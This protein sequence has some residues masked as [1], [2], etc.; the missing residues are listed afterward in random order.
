MGR[1]R[2]KHVTIYT[3]FRSGVRKIGWCLNSRVRFWYPD[4]IDNHPIL[5]SRRLTKKGVTARDEASQ[6]AVTPQDLGAARA[7]VCVPVVFSEG[8]VGVLCED[9]LYPGFVCI[10]R[11]RPLQPLRENVMT[12]VVTPL[13]SPQDPSDRVASRRRS[14]GTEI[15]STIPRG[16]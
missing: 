15:V 3:I 13:V 12:C 1:W 2:Q 4:P 7:I 11:A 8:D 9:P 14:N 6:F 10:V 16:T 5:A